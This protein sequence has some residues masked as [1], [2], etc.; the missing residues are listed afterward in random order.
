MFYNTPLTVSELKGDLSV[1][2]SY[3]IMPTAHTSALWSYG[4]PRHTSGGV[5]SGVPQDV[6]A[7][8]S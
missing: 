2:S 3:K 1:I 8:A 6:I 7:L 5:K 4:L